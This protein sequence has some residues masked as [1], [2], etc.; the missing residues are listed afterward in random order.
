MKQTYRVV[1]TVEVEPETDLEHFQP[2]LFCA[3]LAGTDW[4]F[5]N[6]SPASAIQWLLTNALH[7]H[8]HERDEML[9]SIAHR[10]KDQEP[11]YTVEEVSGA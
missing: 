1:L 2:G 7:G 4:K 5:V 9:S 8:Y 11:T 3:T 10:H 6:D